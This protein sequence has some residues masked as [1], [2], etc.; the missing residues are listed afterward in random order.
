MVARLIILALAWLAAWSFPSSAAVVTVLPSGDAGLARILAQAQPGDTIR[1]APGRHRLPDRLTPARSGEEGRPIV[2]TGSGAEQT[3]IEA[4]GNKYGFLLVKK[5][6][7]VIRDLTLTGFSG[8]G[9]KLLASRH[10]RLEGLTV[11]GSSSHNI[12]LQGATAN[13]VIGCRLENSAACGLTV[14]PTEDGRGGDLNLIQG[15]FSR[16]NAHQGFL[17]T[18]RFNLIK[19]NTAEANGTRTPYDHGFYIVGRANR[20]EGNQARSNP[21][22]SGIRIGGIEH[23]VRDNRLEKNGRAGV[24]VAGTNRSESIIII[25]NLIADNAHAGV[26][27]NSLKYQP[28]RIFIGGNLFLNN[29]SQL[30]IKSGVSRV[31]V[32]ANLFEAPGQIQVR[33]DG[34]AEEVVFK[35]N[36]FVGRGCRFIRDGQRLPA[37]VFLRRLQRGGRCSVLTRSQKEIYSRFGPGRGTDLPWSMPGADREKAP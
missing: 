11:T 16:G 19:A 25:D 37:E 21:H 14:A 26:E 1:L 31:E 3:I 17:V 4:H 9:V 5:S 10:C 2:I 20:L 34:L 18:G 35:K 7:I 36:V 22:G 29:H 23:L 13:R 8:C 28:S 12:F 6:Y 24:V 27:I 15:N 30:W 33:F 32:T